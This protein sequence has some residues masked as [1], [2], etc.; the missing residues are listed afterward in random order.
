VAA[1]AAAS[2]ARNRRRGSSGID[3]GIT[4]PP[5]T[6]AATA[7]AAAGANASSAEDAS[8]FSTSD[9]IAKGRE[10]IEAMRRA[11]G[12]K[13]KDKPCYTVWQLKLL[14]EAVDK[15]AKPWQHLWPR[16]MARSKLVAPAERSPHDS[17]DEGDFTEHAA[18]SPPKR[19]TFAASAA[20]SAAPHRHY[21]SPYGP[22]RY[23]QRVQD[24][25]WDTEDINVRVFCMVLS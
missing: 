6:A 15:A 10:L 4:S 22:P 16:G 13:D 7:A 19:S 24:G 17:G 18:R 5:L 14:R 21:E 23:G 20:T 12:D 25:D 1:A 3:A 2:G 9:S 8:L 11:S